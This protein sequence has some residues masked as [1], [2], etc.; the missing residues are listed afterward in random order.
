MDTETNAS[1]WAQL[2]DAASLALAIHADQ[3]RKGTTTPY[4][5][6]LMAVA[7]IVLEHG[8]DE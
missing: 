4:I 1:R 8:G 6:H 3:V 2:A 7:A 5:S